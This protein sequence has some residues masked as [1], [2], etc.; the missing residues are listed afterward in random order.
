[1]V[2]NR[3]PDWARPVA[4]DEELL[5]LDWAD[6]VEARLARIENSLPN[7]RLLEKKFLLRAFAVVGHEIVGYL[8]LMI[9]IC[10][11]VLIMIILESLGIVSY[12]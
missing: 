8:V 5:T 2:E 12:R 11:L 6:A 3:T 10:I 4:K 1:M 9:P 7:T